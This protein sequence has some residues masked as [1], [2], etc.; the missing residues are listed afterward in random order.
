M[1]IHKT[2]IRSLGGNVRGVRR[3]DEVVPGIRD[4][5]RYMDLLKRIGFSSE[6]AVGETVLP[7]AVGPVTQFNAEGKYEIHR[8]QP[9]ETAYRQAEWRWQ[10]FRGPYDTEEMSRIVEI[11]YERYP[12]TFVPPPSIELSVKSL[13]GGESILV[14]PP[15]R[16]APSNDELLLHCINVF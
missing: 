14:T 10:E 15:L 8:D 9:K 12:R 11:P 4:L 2:R 5:M 16:F 1:I 7:T 3:G 6:L 13:K